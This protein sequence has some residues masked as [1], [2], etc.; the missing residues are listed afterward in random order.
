M[1]EKN[2]SNVGRGLAMFIIASTI[3]ASIVMLGIL[4]VKEIL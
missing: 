3:I 4:I 2:E 1:E